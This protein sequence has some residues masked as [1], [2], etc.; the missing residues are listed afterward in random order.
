VYKA[1]SNERFR[2]EVYASRRSIQRL[3]YLCLIR[4]KI[5]NANIKIHLMCQFSIIKAQNATAL[6]THRHVTNGK[7]FIDFIFLFFLEDF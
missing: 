7:I 5:C 3:N 2:T 6:I 1:F 4:A